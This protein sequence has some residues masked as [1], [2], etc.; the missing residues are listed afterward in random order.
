MNDEDRPVTMA[1]FKRLEEK[2]DDLATST[3]ALVEA[4]NTATGVVKFVKLLST[5]I[6]AVGAIWLF[7]KHGFKAGG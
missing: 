6:A 7:I 5:L 4:W 3:K 2:F 1:E